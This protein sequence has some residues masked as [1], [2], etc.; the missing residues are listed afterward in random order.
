MTG[1]RATDKELA[2]EARA[3]EEGQLDPKNWQDAPEALINSEG[4]MKPHE[5]FAE[6]KKLLA[7]LPER[8]QRRIFDLIEMLMRA[9]IPK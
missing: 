8:N 4:R 2:Q 7:G 6:L 5:I 1:K 3:W 9:H